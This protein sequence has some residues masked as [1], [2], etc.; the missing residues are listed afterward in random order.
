MAVVREVVVPEWAILCVD[1][2]K[3]ADEA[4]NKIYCQLDTEAL[5]WNSKALEL[6]VDT[7]AAVA[8]L[9]EPVYRQHFAHCPL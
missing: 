6:I 1:D 7:G 8:I 5:Q 4:F 3:L 9:P 2:I